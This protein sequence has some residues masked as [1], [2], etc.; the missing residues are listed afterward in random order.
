MR[1]LNRNIDILKYVM[2]IMIIMIHVGYSYQIPV[3]RV[4]V[5]VFFIISSYL[6]FHSIRGV[7][8]EDTK[9]YIRFLKRALKLYFFWFVVLLPFTI[10]YRGWYKDDLLIAIVK[11]IKGLFLQSTFPASWYISAYIIG[12]S[13]LFTLRNQHKI[14][15][16]I[17][18]LAYI[19]CCASSNYCYVFNNQIFEWGGVNIENTFLVGLVYIYIGK[20]FVNI[21]PIHK[22]AILLALLGVVI[23]VVLLSIEN[24]I[25]ISHGF[26]RS[27][28]SYLSLLI[29]A[30]CVFLLFKELPQFTKL[31]TTTI[32]RMSTIYYCSHIP[33]IFI[34]RFFIKNVEQ[35]TLFLIVWLICTLIS[36]SLIK[37][38]KLSRMQWVRF[39]Y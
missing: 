10:I 1:I 18:V 9:I 3:L 22:R 32:R 35:L 39:S 6:F 33:I 23:G 11:L 21:H 31:N 37:I 19:L 16:V 26:R 34:T 30:P 13:I 38:S 14:T 8:E 5:P 29:L 27:D 36:I 7:K 20:C 2:S 24:N 28:D 15:C 4:A 25:I 12:I 17:S